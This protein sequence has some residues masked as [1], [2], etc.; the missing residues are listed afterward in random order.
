MPPQLVVPKEILTRRLRLRRYRPG[1]DEAFGGLQEIFELTRDASIADEQKAP[2]EAEAFRQGT[3]AIVDT[4]PLMFAMTITL[5][6]LDR[7]VGSCGLSPTSQ[8]GV[9]EVFF[10]LLPSAQGHGYATE[11][12]HALVEF[13]RGEGFQHMVARVFDGNRPSIGVLE[14]AGFQTSQVVD[15]ELGSI[16]IYELN[17]Q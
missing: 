15:G 3:A 11:T 5:L 6:A 7:P 13:A 8:G 16:S 1:D 14:R 17:L 4:A 10:T 9:I 12:V 2:S